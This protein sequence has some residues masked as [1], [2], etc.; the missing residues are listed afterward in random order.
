MKPLS[1]PRIKHNE[2]GCMSNLIWILIVN[3]QPALGPI[4]TNIVLQLQGSI[5]PILQT[6]DKYML[7]HR[8]G[9]WHWGYIDFQPR[10]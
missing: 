5:L 3:S 8:E 6:N 1:Y 10:R 9:W 4:G 7:V 2:K